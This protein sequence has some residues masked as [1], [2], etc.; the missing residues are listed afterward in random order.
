[1]KGVT[2]VFIIVIDMFAAV[3][4]CGSAAIDIRWKLRVSRKFGLLKFAEQRRHASALVL[5]TFGVVADAS[6]MQPVVTI[7]S[8]EIMSG[9]IS[10]SIRAIVPLAFQITTAG[11]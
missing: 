10:T 4:W 3:C 11:G 7:V 8:S 1:M 2:R 6:T 5:I 9:R